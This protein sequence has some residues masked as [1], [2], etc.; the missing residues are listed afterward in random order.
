MRD[1]KPIVVD[2][3]RSGNTD[4]EILYDFRQHSFFFEEEGTRERHHAHTFVE[5]RRLVDQVHE[6]AQPLAW[7][8]VILVDLRG[9]YDDG[10]HSARSRVEE[11]ASVHLTFRRCELSPV[12]HRAEVVARVTSEREV[13]ARLNRKRHRS[14]DG[15]IERVGFIEREHE[16]DFEAGDPSDSDR[17]ARARSL[18]R[19]DTYRNSPDVVELPYDEQTWRGLL[20]M[21]R[22]IDDLHSKVEVLIHQSD[23]RDRLRRIASGGMSALPE[24]EKKS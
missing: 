22:A 3:V 24:K 5:V 14:D 2:K 10:D 15:P 8:P 7:A 6:D 17:E 21:K 16:V 18:D 11:G 9:K 20:A 1:R 19:S 13:D 4:V 12:P 23:F